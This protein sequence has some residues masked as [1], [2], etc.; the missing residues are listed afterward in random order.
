MPI[1]YVTSSL[2]QSL[3]ILVT[4][5]WISAADPIRLQ[6]RGGADLLHKRQ[7]AAASCTDALCVFSEYLATVPS[8]LLPKSTKPPSA[9]TTKPPANDQPTTTTDKPS[10]T[11][12]ADAAGGAGAN[13]RVSVAQPSLCSESAL[14]FSSSWSVPTGIIQIHSET[15]W[16]EEGSVWNISANDGVQLANFR[17]P[18][19]GSACTGITGN[20]VGDGDIFK[21]PD[22]S[23]SMN[24]TA[25]MQPS[26]GLFGDASGGNPSEG[27]YDLS[28]TSTPPCA[29]P[30]FQN[31]SARNFD[32]TADQWEAYSAGDFLL[33]YM[34]DNNINSLSDLHAKASND[35]LPTIDAQGRICNPDAGECSLQSSHAQS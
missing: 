8:S 21:N 17:V 28:I 27:E 10:S 2:C 23:W 22:G 34:K 1:M 25:N 31:C 18:C 11:T 6:H 20:Q 33:K 7:D 9:T 14:Q 26:V 15:G 5:A 3:V 13:I 16:G 29:L 32:P 30:V 4:A 19:Q 35:F 12:A 24:V